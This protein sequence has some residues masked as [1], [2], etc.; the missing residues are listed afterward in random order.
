MNEIKT[1]S[2]TIKKSAVVIIFLVLCLIFST[3]SL[4]Y[5]KAQDES[6]KINLNGG[7][8]VV[9][10]SNFKI[11]PGMTLER[12]FFIKNESSNRL[13]YSLYFQNMEG[14]LGNII[15][16]TFYEEDKIILS[17]LMADLTKAKVNNTIGSLNP[18]EKKPL[19]VVFAFPK[20]VTNEYKK[21]S[22]QFDIGA[23]AMWSA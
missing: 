16:A 18:Y 21:A 3:F 4:A 15:T 13:G 20:E 7:L 1:I 2:E 17:G 23:V 14:S 5:I 9:E 19:K 10:E 11:S 12:D 22:L 6:C 8:P